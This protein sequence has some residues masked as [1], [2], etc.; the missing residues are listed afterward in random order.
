[1]CIKWVI[2]ICE[3]QTASWAQNKIDAIDLNKNNTRILQCIVKIIYHS[4]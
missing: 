1:M 4:A 3:Y 2:M